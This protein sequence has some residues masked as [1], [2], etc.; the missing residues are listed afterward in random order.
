MLLA[1]EFHLGD[2]RE[3]VI[4]GD[5]G[6]ETTRAMLSKLRQEFPVH[7]VIA[8]VHDGNREDLER[9]SPVFKGKIRV[10]GKPTAYVCRRGVCEAPVTDPGQ[11]TLK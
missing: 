2:P 5:P 4:A 9:I 6:D 3:V 8:V 10:D 7:H 1:V 11:I